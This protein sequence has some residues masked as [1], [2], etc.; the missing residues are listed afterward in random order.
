MIE[1]TLYYQKQ[2]KRSFR[3]KMFSRPLNYSKLKF[4]NKHHNKIAICEKSK[5]DGDLK[6]GMHKFDT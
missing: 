3:K 4:L 2:L 6:F 1:I 5:I